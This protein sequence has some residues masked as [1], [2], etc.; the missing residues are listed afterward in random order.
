MSARQLPLR[1]VHLPPAP[2]WWPPAPGWWLL[3]AALLV[4]LAVRVF[5]SWRRRRRQRRWQGLFDAA[6]HDAETPAARLAAAS[7]MLRRAAKRI[8][9][10]AANLQGDA[11]LQFLDGTK[12]QDFSRGDGRLLLEGGYRR[13]VDADIAR[14][15]CELARTRFVELMAGR[16]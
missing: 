2:D 16:R 6:L 11:W 8:D 12:R 4:G 1:D 10:A 13:Q 7:G 5:F 15:A 9:A 3:F 14:A